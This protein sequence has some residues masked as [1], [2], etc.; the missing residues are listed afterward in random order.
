[1]LNFDGCWISASQQY[2][3]SR[4]QSKFSLIQP[5]N[6]LVDIH[7]HLCIADFGLSKSRFREDDITNS[8]CGSPDYMAPEVMESK[9][10]NFSSDF[11]SIGAILYEFITGLPPYYEHGNHDEQFDQRL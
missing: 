8:N 2:S 7:G 9:S 5:E 11:Y 6:I 1:M 4:S 3:I 10:Y